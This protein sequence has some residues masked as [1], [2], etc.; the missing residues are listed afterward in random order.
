MKVI[1]TKIEKDKVEIT[2]SDNDNIDLAENWCRVSQSLSYTE[3]ML[4]EAYQLECLRSLRTVIGDEI[5]R[6][7]AIVNCKT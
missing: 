1:S 3:G 2:F 5:Q 6:L 7:T 4:F